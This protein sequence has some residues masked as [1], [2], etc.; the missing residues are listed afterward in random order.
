MT[1]AGK[2]KVLF[3][4]SGLS[5]G[6]AE[7]HTVALRA[8]LRERG[9]DTALLVYGTKTSKSIAEMPGAEDPIR[10]DTVGMSRPLGW[11]AAWRALRRIDADVLIAVNQTPLIVSVALR[12]VGGIRSRIACVFH[13]TV[14]RP[15][16]ESRLAM[17]RWAAKLA[18][19]FVFISRNQMRYW[20]LRGIDCVRT[21]LITNGID[22]DH[23]RPQP[24]ERKRLR[25]ELGLAD[26]EVAFGLVATFRPEKNHLQLLEALTAVRE[27]GIKARVIFVG[28]GPTFVAV[29]AAVAKAGLAGEVI[30]AGEQA[31][32]R[33][34]IAACDVGVLC[35][36]AVETYS[37]AAIEFLAG[38]VPMLMSDIGGA[39]EIV[40]DGVNG[41]LFKVDDTAELIDRMTQMAEPATLARLKAASRPSTTAMSEDRMVDLYADLVEELA[42]QPDHVERG[43][44]RAE[45][46]GALAARPAPAMAAASPGMGHDARDD[47]AEALPVLRSD[48]RFQQRW[49]QDTRTPERIMAHYLLERRLAARLRSSSREERSVYYAQAYS[50][51]FASLPDHPQNTA[52]RD[53]AGDR[54]AA[55]SKLLREWLKPD[56]VYLEI[57]CGDAALTFAVAP[58]VRE[59]IGVDVTPDLID[60]AKAPA[61]F[62]FVLS[63]GSDIDLPDASVDVVYSNQVME[64]IHVDDVEAQLREIARVLKPGGHYLCATPNRV[65]GPTDVS[66]YFDDEP[67]GF[68]M[69]EYDVGELQVMFLKAGFSHVGFLVARRGVIFARPPYALLRGVERIAMSLPAR[70]RRRLA[71]LLRPVLGINAV[72]RR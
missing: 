60:G 8:R 42:A 5:V 61:N 49:S 64:H 69:K 2:P 54:I 17:F 68:H 11:L 16:D 12:R 26:D 40:T 66:K 58:K 57:G 35:S 63:S 27:R 22:L 19:A 9:F 41:Y 55:Q 18:D 38:G 62:R 52:Q 39:S 65:I 50:E 20:R 31:D 15:S 4:V 24:D 14:L 13:T 32:V 30:F 36:N 3:F 67:T 1:T 45:G 46:V 43:A 51:L 37:L 33:P 25:A 47:R 53:A 56:T 34:W 29:E 48:H 10:L 44:F 7:R 59:A 23:F 6:G 70:L 71:P 21:P 28:N 72:A